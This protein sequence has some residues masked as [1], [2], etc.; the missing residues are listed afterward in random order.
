M[1]HHPV[2]AARITPWLRLGP[3][4]GSFRIKAPPR[5]ARRDRGPQVWAPYV[6]IAQFLH[7]SDRPGVRPLHI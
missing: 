7:R 3:A 4:P 2:W 6:S 5:V 1:T